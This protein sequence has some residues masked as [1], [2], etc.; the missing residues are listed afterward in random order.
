MIKVEVKT[1][2]TK[3][4]YKVTFSVINSLRNWLPKYSSIYSFD[5]IGKKNS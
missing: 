5:F 1:E 2:N 4:R 3:F